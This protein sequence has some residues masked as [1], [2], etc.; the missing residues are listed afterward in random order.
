M[1]RPAGEAKVGLKPLGAAAEGVDVVEQP[2]P[3][4]LRLRGFQT[5]RKP[6]E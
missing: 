2:Q 6:T 4:H 1:R 3:N 5:T